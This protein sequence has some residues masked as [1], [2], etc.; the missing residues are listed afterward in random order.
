ARV[1]LQSFL[2]RQGRRW[3]RKT[4][5]T[6]EHLEW[7]RAQP[8][9]HEAHH[10]VLVAL[11]LAVEQGSEQVKRLTQDIEELVA[12]SAINP[13][14]RAL[15]ALRGIQLLTASIIAAEIGNFDRFASAPD[16]MA[17]L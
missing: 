2:L 14:I 1:Q 5:W 10:R 13:L 11:V 9:D 16:L 4:P 15:Q 7:I 8:F 6:R 3:E 17:Y 12:A